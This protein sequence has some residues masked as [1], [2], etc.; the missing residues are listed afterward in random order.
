MPRGK[1]YRT[2]SIVLCGMIEEK[3][4]SLI[5][6]EDRTLDGY[7]MTADS[8]RKLFQNMRKPYRIPVVLR[9]GAID[10]TIGDV[11]AIRAGR[12]EA[13]ADLSLGLKGVLEFEAVLDEK[14]GKKIGVYPS[15][16]VYKKES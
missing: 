13:F 8:L 9:V 12:D 1:F 14:T 11:N 6:Y 7:P 5:K 4:A 3:N 2:S 15:K 16:F 10:Q